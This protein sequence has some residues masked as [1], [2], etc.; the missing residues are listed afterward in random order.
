[1]I[2]RSG[3]GRYK[4]VR[5]EDRKGLEGEIKGRMS[6]REQGK[7]RK[8]GEERQERKESQEGRM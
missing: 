3:K 4:A 8:K 6:E 1:M 5:G 2:E 7:K